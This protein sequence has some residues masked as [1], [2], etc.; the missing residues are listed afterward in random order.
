M[1]KNQSNEKLASNDHLNQ[2]QSLLSLPFQ[3][4][5]HSTTFERIED[6][7]KRAY[8]ELLK[9]KSDIQQKETVAQK[10]QW[11]DSI[12]NTE[13]AQPVSVIPVPVP[14]KFY[15]GKECILEWPG[16]E[17]HCAFVQSGM[18]KDAI[19][20]YPGTTAP[21]SYFQSLYQVPAEGEYLVA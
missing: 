12:L 5:Q 18:T 2:N 9:S 4:R 15:Q 13:S 14:D 7:Q 11:V 6:S 19:K 1:E 21:F 3:S 16:H 17:A 8:E 20:E 10:E